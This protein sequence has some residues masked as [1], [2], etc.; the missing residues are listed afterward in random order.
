MILCGV[1]TSIGSGCLTLIDTN[2]PTVRWAVYLVISGLGIGSGV[3]LPY[4]ALQAVL[5]SVKL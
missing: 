4:S 5:V 3:Q 1:I 2:T